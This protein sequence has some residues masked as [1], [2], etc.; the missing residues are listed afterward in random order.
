MSEG[1][2]ELD[3]ARIGFRVGGEGPPLLLVRPLGGSIAMWGRFGEALSRSFRTIAYDPPGAG[4]SSAP[5]ATITTRALARHAVAV[6]DEVG[7]DRAHVFG[8]SLGGMIA[9]WLAVDAPTRVDR[10]VL[11]STMPWGLSGRHAS[12]RRGLA[13]ARC[14]LLPDEDCAAC[15]VRRVLSPDFVRARR[16]EV[17]GLEAL[18]RASAGGRG[19][20]VALA[21][22]AA[23]HDARRALAR[24]DAETLVLGGAR[25]T[26]AAPASQRWMV[27][28][29]ARARFETIDCG[30]DL[31]LEAP[32]ET[33]QRV[34]SFLVGR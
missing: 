13:F 20:I 22:A 16:D 27:Q 33:A 9:T 6:L 19:A 25:D 1:V 15:L 4:R 12:P 24:I 3:G 34:C 10:L 30:H 8:I 18:A 29:I 26:L 5:P 31:T 7:V 17:A 2:V 28:E 23:R 14:L 32:D 11:A 21:A